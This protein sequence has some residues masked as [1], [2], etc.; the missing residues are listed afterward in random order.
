MQHVFNVAQT[1]C[2]YRNTE[3]MAMM[4]V[5]KGVSRDEQYYD[6]EQGRMSAVFQFSIQ[7]CTW[8]F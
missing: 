2:A 4:I 6:V 5:V 3:M 1:C 7:T 8:S